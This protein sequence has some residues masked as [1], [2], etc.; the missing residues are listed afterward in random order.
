MIISPGVALSSF[1][2]FTGFDA[3]KVTA[4]FRIT[5]TKDEEGPKWKDG[6]CST[7]PKKDLIPGKHA[8]ESVIEK[9]E[10]HM[11]GKR[12]K[13]STLEMM[14]S[15]SP[16]RFC[17]E[18]LTDMFRKIPGKKTFIL[19][20][21][22]IYTRLEVDGTP[23]ENLG[24]WLASLEME[25]VKVK[26]HPVDVAR[27]LNSSE[28]LLRRRFGRTKWTKQKKKELEKQPKKVAEKVRMVREEIRFMKEIIRSYKVLKRELASGRALSGKISFGQ[29]SKCL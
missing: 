26:I 4:L 12:P 9:V 1:I 10:E 14:L 24:K 27:E 23:T 22:S 11:I 21:A 16:C 8:E 2:K 7:I 13:Q 25:G 15:H 3:C 18:K 6:Y 5:T 19:R 29:G 17:R 28:S 20:V